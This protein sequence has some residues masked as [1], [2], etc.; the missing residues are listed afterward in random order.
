MGISDFIN[1]HEMHFSRIAATEVRFH[2][3]I[4]PIEPI[5]FEVLTHQYIHPLELYATL[6]MEYI[7]RFLG[8]RHNTT[9]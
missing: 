7:D 8:A 5:D 4:R 9:I 3:F 1:M 2:I 6:F